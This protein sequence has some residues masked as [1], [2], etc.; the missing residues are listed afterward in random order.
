M[1][2][3]QSVNVSITPQLDRFVLNLVAAGRYNTV[4]EVFREGL[5]LLEEAE[6][7]RMLEDWFTENLSPRERAKIPQEVLD[8]AGAVIANKIQEGLSEAAAGKSPS[9]RKLLERWKAHLDTVAKASKGRP[10]AKRNV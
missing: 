5:R 4:S 1:S 8:G 9:G 6:R 3:R 2:I 10:R 7:R